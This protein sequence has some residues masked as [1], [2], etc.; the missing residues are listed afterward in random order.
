MLTFTWSELGSRKERE[1]V[2][3]SEKDRPCLTKMMTPPLACLSLGE[4]MP[5]WKQRQLDCRESRVAQRG[6]QVEAG[7]LDTSKV[8][9]ME[10][11]IV[12]KISAPSSKTPGIQLKNPE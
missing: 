3:N 11:D 7:F 8:H 5:E 4:R 6:R 2:E 9:R 12:E 10:Q 1:V